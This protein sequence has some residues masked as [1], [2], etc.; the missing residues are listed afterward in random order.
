[1]DTWPNVGCCLSV[2]LLVTAMAQVVVANENLPAGYARVEYIQGDGSTCDVITDF[3]PNP[4]TDM[5]TCELEIT[6]TSHNMFVFS[7]RRGGSDAAWSLNL[8]FGS[9]VGYRFDYASSQQ[10]SSQACQ[11]G[12]KYKFVVD[13]NVLTRSPGETLTAQAVPTFT[14]AGG[15]MHLF[16]TA[17]NTTSV[18]NFKIFS[19]RIFRNNAIIHD[20]VP[21][22]DEKGQPQFVDVVG[23]LSITMEGKFSAGKVISYDVEQ[24]LEGEVMAMYNE[25]NPVVSG[26]RKYIALAYIT[27]THKCKRVSGDDDP[28]NPVKDYWYHDEAGNPQLVDPEPSIR[29]LGKVA[30]QAGFDALIHA[31]DFSTAVPAKPFEERDYLNEIRNV[32]AMVSENLPDTPFFAV[33]GNHDREYW[34]AGHTSGHSMTDAEWAAV[35]DEINTD[36]SGN[37]MIDCRAGIGNNYV[38]DFKR[39]LASGGKNVR[40]VMTSIFDKDVSSDLAS[41]IVEGFAFP[42][43]AVAAGDTIFGIT[44]HD[45]RDALV[46]A[47]KVSQRKFASAGF[48]GTICGDRHK[49]S[50]T[51]IEG[52]LSHYVCVKNAFSPFGDATRGAYHFSIF[53]FDTDANVV[54]E[55]CLSGVGDNAPALVDHPIDRF[56]DW[57]QA[58]AR[59]L[60]AVGGNGI[61]HI[62]TDFVPNPQTDKIVVTL[63]LPSLL[64]SQYAFAARSGG[65][66]VNTTYSLNLRDSGYRF[67]YKK[68]GTP[69]GTLQ[70][71]VKYTF[72]AENNVMTWSGGEST[73]FEKDESFTAAGG[74][75]W[76][77]ASKDMSASVGNSWLYSLQI[78][79]S[80][81]LI[82][83]L[84]P[85]LADNGGATLVDKIKD[86][87]AMNLVTVG[88]EPFTPIYDPHPDPRP[89]KGARQLEWI[90]GDGVSGYFETEFIPDPSRDKMEAVVTLTDLSKD[91][92]LFG[93]RNGST[94]S[95]GSWA[96]QVRGKTHIR[97]DYNASG[98]PQGRALKEGVKYVFTAET[99]TLSW[100]HGDGIV[101]TK[102]LFTPASGP[103]FILFAAGG[104]G[105]HSSCKL[106]SFRIWRDGVL[107]HE[108]LPT[109]MPFGGVRLMDYGSDPI[110]VTGRGWF[111]AGPVKLRRGLMLILK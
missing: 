43:P 27:D 76:L 62:E 45:H 42:D 77:F 13:R 63:E 84:Q 65:S 99:N 74:P 64:P 82:H 30:A 24:E 37:P 32:K 103:L 83:D 89:P 66:D 54:H 91:Q 6:D 85:Q 48:F 72:T 93:A 20:L 47:A 100:S 107:I 90:Q 1:M 86:G 29:L 33:D 31:G 88:G 5:I 28:S 56:L 41:R 68:S 60:V 52:T 59:K 39:C 16:R 11:L 53:V 73:T 61:S 7:A 49:S 106:H 18:G 96:L 12:A 4:Q 22:V 98:D 101:S 26:S 3:V 25:L 23:K 102:P 58:D 15:P 51:V 95:I 9:P 35:L 67:D 46:T 40:L 92:F 36:V 108:F 17:G 69:K 80:G 78:Y 87:K 14:A 50:S 55:I 2:T 94:G 10:S 71:S 105:T 104:S 111:R 75:L 109:R 38:L 79:R 44:A 110:L 34:N 19:F 70:K 81:K 8:L 57:E 97:Y 21:A